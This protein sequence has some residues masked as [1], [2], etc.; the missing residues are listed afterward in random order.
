VPIRAVIFDFGGVLVRTEDDRR[1]RAW[2]K[3]LGLARREADRIVFDSETAL[4]AATGQLDEAE[5]WR[6]VGERLG[7]SPDQTAEFRRDFFAGDQLDEA[8]V[9]LIE[10][11]HPRYKT[12]LLTNC[13][14]RRR[15][16]LVAYGMDGLF[17]VNV[18]SCEVGVGK[19]DARIY[20]EALAQLQ[21][22]PEEAVFIDDHLPNVEA[23]RALGMH[24]VHFRDTPS[25]RNELSAILH[26]QQ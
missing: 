21:V 17:D 12:A 24:A 16:E 7:L 4:L 5:H 15:Q 20:S 8:L 22:A 1:R 19:P 13:W 2:E 10:S 14:P 9:A 23:A 6:W 11:L 26:E 25:L 3:R 18:L